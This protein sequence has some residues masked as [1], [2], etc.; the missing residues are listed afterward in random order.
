LKKKKLKQ[1]KKREEEEEGGPTVVCGFF[2]FHF[3]LSYLI[4]GDILVF[5]FIL[6]GVNKKL[7][8]DERE[9]SQGGLK[10]RIL[11]LRLLIIV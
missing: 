10:H 8:M 11:T 1:K 4:S 7:I 6:L 9:G 3:F 5:L 2:I